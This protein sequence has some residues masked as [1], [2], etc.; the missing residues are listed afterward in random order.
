MSAD[1]S[2]FHSVIL[3]QD[4]CKGCTVCVTT[5][6][7]EA[8][9]VRDGKAFIIEE[10][11]IDCGEC[12]RRCPNHAKKARSDALESLADPASPFDWKIALPA[13]SLYGQFPD[14]A[15]VAEIHRALRSLGF[16]EVFPVSA[17][18][19]LVARATRAYLARPDARRPVISSSCPTIIKYIQIRFPSLIEHVEPVIAPMELAAR[20][21]KS[22]ARR[23]LP[24]GSR[25]GAFFISPCAG[26]ITETKAPLSGGESA[27][28]GVFS[29]KDVVLPIIAALKNDGADRIEPTPSAPAG[30]SAPEISWGR[31]EGEAAMTVAGS[32]FRYLAV[33]GIELCA[34]VLESCENGKLPGIDFLE[35]MACREGCVGGPLVASSP[36]LARHVL[37][38]RESSAPPAATP[39]DPAGEAPF[40]DPDLPARPALLLDGDYRKARAMMAEMERIYA[41]LPGLDC[42]CCG[43]PNC[44]ALAEDIV[45][46]KASKTDCV[47]ILKEQYRLLLEEGK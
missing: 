43:A 27:V 33:D 35:L 34:Q 8:I 10:R 17:A 12:I 37:T 14:T 46:G 41:E 1:G 29:V 5:C 16:D 11:C 18:T 21:A 47:I 6:P 25:V 39:P 24:A 7:A 31:R 30:D 40:R 44:H 3:D 20:I 26:K 9:R 15:P 4:A 22:R 13:P 38:L 19:E 36:T 32:P 23:R 45:R 28:D 42:G 2:R